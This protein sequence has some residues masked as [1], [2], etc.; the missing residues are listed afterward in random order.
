MFFV[1]FFDFFKYIFCF[2]SL[3]QYMFALLVYCA[4]VCIF[5]ESML[6]I[7]T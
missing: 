1:I 3:I 4:A 5:T 6:D 2:D 7:L